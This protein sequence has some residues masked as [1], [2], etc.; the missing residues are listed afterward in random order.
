MTPDKHTNQELF[1]EVGDGHELYIH[2][3]GNKSAK[4]VIFALHGGPGNGSSDRYKDL[5]DPARQRVIFHDQRGSGRSLPAGSLEHNTTKK[6]VEDITKIADK[7]GI[8]TFILTGGSWGSTLAL[9]YGLQYPKRVEAMVLDGIF[10]G[11]QTEIDWL[12][13]GRF[14]T[15]YPDAWDNFRHTVPKN[16][17]QDP[18]TYHAKRIL[19]KDEQAIKE[20]AHAYSS[21]EGAVLSLD[22]RFIPSPLDDYDPNG[23]RIE[24]QYLTN[25]CFMPDR[26]I[27]ENAPKLTMPIWLVQGR[28]DMVCPP[29]A[30]YELHK[31]LPRSELV[32]AISGHRSEHETWNLKRTILLQL[33]D[34]PR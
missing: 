19:G 18:T 14:K 12:N 7:L 26:H 27:L 31:R 9:A 21:M 8:K 4:R 1:L 13:Q 6:L 10:T 17:Q 29:L 2:D 11:S 20:S 23:M 15:F 30:A 24:V 25:G 3:W 28:Y 22:D 34:H 32:F 33:T 16:H 5:Y